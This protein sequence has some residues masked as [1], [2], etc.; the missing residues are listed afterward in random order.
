[1]KVEEQH[2]RRMKKQKK[3]QSCSDSSG[4]ILYFRALQGHSGRSLIDPL[5]QDNV[6]I[7]DGCYKYIDHVGCAINLHSMI[8][9][10]LIPREQI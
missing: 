1:M 5:L 9:S 10:G 7:P 8:N 3:I 6:I 4:Q 2:R